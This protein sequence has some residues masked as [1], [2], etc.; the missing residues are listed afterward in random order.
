[1]LAQAYA[2]YF[3]DYTSKI[4]LVS[5][6][7]PNLSTM[8]A[9]RDNMNMR[10]FPNERDSLEYWQNQPS[11]NYSKMKQSYYS[12]IPEFYDHDIAH[13]ML[14]IFFETTTYNSEMGNKLWMNI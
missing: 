5:T 13:K 8:Q 1:M 2:A 12:Y 11:G 9:F 6:L 14:P 3:P 7:G 4:I 10:R